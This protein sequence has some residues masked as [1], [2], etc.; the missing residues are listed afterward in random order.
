LTWD[1]YL[2]GYCVFRDNRNNWPPFPSLSLSSWNEVPGGILFSL[3]HY[4]TPK[5]ALSESSKLQ[6]GISYTPDSANTG[7]D[8]PSTKSDGITKYAIE[9]P[10]LERFEMCYR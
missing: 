6:F 8:K 2:A 4:Y 9:E 10:T 5:F 7:I 1:S 3:Y